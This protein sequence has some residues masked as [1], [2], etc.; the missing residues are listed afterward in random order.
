MNLIETPLCNRL[1]NE[2]LNAIRLSLQSFHDEHLEK[3]VNYFLTQK[4]VV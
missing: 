3:S 4:N 2:S 1:T